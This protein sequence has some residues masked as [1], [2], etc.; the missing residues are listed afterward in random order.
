[1]K[2]TLRDDVLNPNEYDWMPLFS[3]MLIKDCIPW[4][5]PYQMREKNIL[6]HEKLSSGILKLKS[7]NL[8]Q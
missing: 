3:E 7:Q 1:M 6:F 5:A 4:Q 2:D 8:R